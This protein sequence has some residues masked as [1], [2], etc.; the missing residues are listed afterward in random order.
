MAAHI[1]T[2]NTCLD[3]KAVKSRAHLL[4]LLLLLLSSD[5][6][7]ATTQRARLWR[8]HSRTWR[9]H[10]F[11]GLS[12]SG[13]GEKSRLGF[14]PAATPR[15]YRERELGVVWRAQSLP[16]I[17]GEAYAKSQ[18]EDQFSIARAYDEFLGLYSSSRE[19]LLVIGNANN[20]ER[21]IVCFSLALLLPLSLSLFLESELRVP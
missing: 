5:Y 19:R 12:L 13:R 2:K 18:Q 21:S 10:L 7:R 1:R 16:W 4:R 17:R 14:T 9:E 6:T 11:F 15:R 3:D 20:V 8:M